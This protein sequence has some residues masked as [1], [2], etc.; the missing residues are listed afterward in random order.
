[1]SKNLSAKYCQENKEKKKKT[2][3]E[4]YQNLFK[5]EKEK[6]I[7]MVVNI[8]KTSKKM[9]NKSLLSKE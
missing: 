7:N 2:A 3:R 6:S 9:E 5:E 4:I 1:M 8:T